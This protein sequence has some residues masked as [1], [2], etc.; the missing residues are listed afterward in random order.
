[1]QQDCRTSKI[2]ANTQNVA[3]DR[4]HTDTNGSERVIHNVCFSKAV[5]FQADD[6]VFTIDY[7][8]CGFWGLGEATTTT[9]K[10]KI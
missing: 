3:I 4:R 9:L 7:K 10:E 5:S 2:R 8:N 6:A 1:M